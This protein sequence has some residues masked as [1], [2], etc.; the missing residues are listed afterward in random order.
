[1]NQ[2]WKLLCNP[3]WVW[4]NRLF[5]TIFCEPLLIELVVHLDFL[6]CFWYTN[7]ILLFYRSLFLLDNSRCHKLRIYF[8][9]WFCLILSLNC[10]IFLLF[11]WFFVVNY[12]QNLSLNLFLK[13]LIYFIIGASIVF[14]IMA[15]W[16]F[17]TSTFIL[18]RGVFIMLCVFFISFYQGFHAINC[19]N[20]NSWEEPR[21]L[22]SWIFFF[23]FF[24]VKFFIC[25]RL[26][27]LI[28]VTNLWFHIMS[29]LLSN[30]NFL[31]LHLGT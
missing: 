17:I 22:W 28:W 30:L 13:H 10:K 9:R 21:I 6:F 11:L 5:Q 27:R 14:V 7:R 12:S 1:M 3:Y 16:V 23:I 25:F 26:N 15:L 8:S 2:S 31:L 20:I 18:V 19:F 4:K 29:K 24:K